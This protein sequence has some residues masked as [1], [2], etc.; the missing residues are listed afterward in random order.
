MPAHRLI[1][2]FILLLFGLLPLTPAQ[3]GLWDNLKQG[4][5]G[6][7]NKGKA[8]VGEAAEVTKDV[9]GKAA[10]KGGAFVTDTKQHFHREGA[11]EELRA[12][13][14]DLAY[15]AMDRLFVDDPEAHVLFDRCFGYA[16]FEMRQVSFGV[17]AGYGYGVAR[18]RE[19]DIPTYM[20][21]ATGG[22]GYSLGV[23]G[24]AFQLVMLFEDEPTYRRF[25]TEGVEGRADANSMVGHQTDYLAKEFREGLVIY[26]LT[27]GGF[28][29]AAG[30]VGMRFWVDE[31]LTQPQPAAAGTDAGASTPEAERAGTPIEPAPPAIL[32]PPADPSTMEEPR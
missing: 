14:D 1:T 19:S 4:A 26:K 22:A 12:Q 32:A 5:A 8:A 13:S 2:L 15:R 3:S 21:M 23:G 17:T 16:V 28:K 31:D 30:L 29:I 18:E 25:L 7:V 20:K 10:E 24:F 27:E 9:A 6:A 11:P